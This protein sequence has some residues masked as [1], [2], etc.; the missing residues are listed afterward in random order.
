VNGR[1]GGTHYE[2]LGVGPTASSAEI[3]DAYRRL[4]RQHHPDSAA[5]RDVGAMAAINE[6]YRVL[7]DA[8]RRAAYDAAMR[9]GPTMTAAPAPERVVAPGPVVVPPPLPPARFPWKLA[10]FMAGVGAT[11]VLVGAALY[12]PGTDPPP[13]NVLR[14]GSCVTIEGN[15][16]ARE[17]NCTGSGEELVVVTIVTAEDPCPEG[18]PAYRD[19]QGMGMACVRPA[20]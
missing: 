17:I 18:L 13:D 15:G 9:H 14:P 16:D 1:E 10:V 2:T 3:R 12:E 7:G 8:A 11:V 4:A 19:R 20:G 5:G 6:A